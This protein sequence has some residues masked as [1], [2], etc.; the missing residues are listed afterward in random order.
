M[1]HS[2]DHSNMLSIRT[3]RRIHIHYNHRVPHEVSN[4]ISDPHSIFD[5]NDH[6][7]CSS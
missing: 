5:Y 3:M 6:N 7:P 4:R 1:V 2:G